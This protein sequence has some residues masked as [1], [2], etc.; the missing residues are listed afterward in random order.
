MES[1]GDF[2]KKRNLTQ[3][4]KED[5]G[6]AM[7]DIRVEMV[8]VI[9]VIRTVGKGTENDPV[10][11]EVQYWKPDGQLIVAKDW[12]GDAEPRRKLRGTWEGEL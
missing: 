1:I 8:Q 7:K 5:Q 2:D 12:L 3:C 11:K 9:R 6:I 10:R 4:G